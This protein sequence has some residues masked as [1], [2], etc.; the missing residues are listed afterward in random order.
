ME[1]ETSLVM[2]DGW[3]TE[4]FDR[5][6]IIISNWSFGL[7]LCFSPSKHGKMCS[8]PLTLCHKRKTCGSLQPM[9]PAGKFPISIWWFQTWLWNFPF[10]NWD[11]IPTPLTNSIIF[12]SRAQPP[13]SNGGWEN[14]PPVDIPG[15]NT[16]RYVNVP[17]FRPYEFWWYSL[18]FWPEI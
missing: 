18:K 1:I 11:V 15:S 12:R 8:K 10:H 17:F 13:T 4:W 7:R 16:S 2:V 9:S 5:D 14:H 3:S 6:L